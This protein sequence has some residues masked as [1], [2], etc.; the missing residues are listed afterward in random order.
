MQIAARYFRKSHMDID[1]LG[2]IDRSVVDRRLAGW[3]IGLRRAGRIDRLLD[4]TGVAPDSG[5]I[6]EQCE[7]N[8]GSAP[9]F[10]P[11]LVER[12]RIEGDWK[13]DRGLDVLVGRHRDE[14]GRAG[15]LA[16]DIDDV[17]RHD[18]EIGDR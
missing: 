1:L 6:A 4:G 5:A 7:I 16:V 13:L 14:I 11:R 8:G 2:A 18:G 3:R 17:R 10:T 12:P 9:E 15:L